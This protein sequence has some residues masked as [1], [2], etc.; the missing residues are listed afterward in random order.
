MYFN[1]LMQL[2]TADSGKD[3]SRHGDTPLPALLLDL[4][5]PRPAAIHINE[6]VSSAGITTQMGLQSCVAV[7]YLDFLFVGTCF[8]PICHGWMI[9]SLST[10]VVSLRTYPALAVCLPWLFFSLSCA[11]SQVGA[12]GL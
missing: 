7:T 2:T 3:L 10:L 4:P 1:I 11:A 6:R 12:D 9:R 5:S 8:Q